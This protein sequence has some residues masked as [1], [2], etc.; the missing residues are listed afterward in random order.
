MILHWLPTNK[1]CQLCL[2]VFSRARSTAASRLCG[3]S[4][5]NLNR[6]TIDFFFLGDR[7]KILI[8]TC[9]KVDWSAIAHWAKYDLCPLFKVA[10]CTLYYQKNYLWQVKRYEWSLKRAHYGATVKNVLPGKNMNPFLYASIWVCSV[11]SCI[12]CENEFPLRG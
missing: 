8:I 4:M 6:L 2:M 10:V 11:F 12:D 5:W 9:V 7:L 1:G 3:C